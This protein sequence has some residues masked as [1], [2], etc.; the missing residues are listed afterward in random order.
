MGALV[1]DEEGEGRECQELCPERDDKTVAQR[2]NFTTV[3][4]AG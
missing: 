2:M 4:G 1:T 3:Q